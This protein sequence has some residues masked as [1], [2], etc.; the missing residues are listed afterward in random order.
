MGGAGGVDF[1]VHDADGVAD[2]LVDGI[3]ASASLLAFA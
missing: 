2:R 1:R 3:S